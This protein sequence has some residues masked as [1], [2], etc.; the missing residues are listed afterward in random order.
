MPFDLALFQTLLF[1]VAMK[2]FY[3]DYFNVNET[4]NVN[5]TNI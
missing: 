4:I 1:L 2:S 5:E 3:N